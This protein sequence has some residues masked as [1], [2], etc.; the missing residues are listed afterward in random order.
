MTRAQDRRRLAWFAPLALLVYVGNA[1]LVRSPP[2]GLLPAGAAAPDWPVL[3]DLLVLV[4]LLYLGLFWR[5]RRRAL[6]GAAMLAL[7]GLV[8]ADWIVPPESRNWLG[9][10]Q[11]G[12]NLLIAAFVAGEIVL[13]VGLAR[14][15]LR[16]LRDGDDP[17]LAIASA[18]HARF[19]DSAVARLLAFEVRMWF[20][21]LF[22]SPRRPLSYAGDEHFSCHA[23]DGHA[24]NQ[25]GFL[26][27]VLLELPIAHVLLALFWHPPAAWIVTALS[28]WGLVYLLGEYRATLRRPI[29]LD[30][31]NLHLRYGLS[32]EL[33]LPLE[34]IASAQPHGERVARRTAGSLR[35]C[36]A[37]VPNVCLIV[38][39]PIEVA[40]LLGQSRPIRRIYLG[41]DAPARFLDH[42][43]GT[44]AGV[45]A[46][47]RDGAST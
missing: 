28:A 8:L 12:R 22:A 26:L 46:R 10:L 9:P 20:Y 1:V 25:Q 17:E 19:G 39:P 34:R 18:L 41:V 47:S 3:F 32:A 43:N 6:A 37:G 42:L 2:T 13:A 16:L 45:R 5:D 11:A 14:M 33:M 24:S 15:T 7:V 29:S 4:P 23:K 36:D 27:L 44:L 21:A 40:G 38:E 30:V 35:Y 31:D